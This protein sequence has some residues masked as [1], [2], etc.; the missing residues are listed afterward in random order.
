[1]VEG[2][3]FFLAGIGLLVY[4]AKETA[5]IMPQYWSISPYMLP[6]IIAVAMIL[7][8][9]I[10]FFQGL[11][12]QKRMGAEEKKAADPINWRG[13]L[14]ACGLVILYYILLP[15]IHFLPATVLFL[16]AFLYFLGERKPLRLVLIPLLTS[17]V[18]YLLFDVALSLMLP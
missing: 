9:V 13:V 12:E 7:M 3:V 2:I 1:M 5:K 17:G 18:L 4:S 14:G 15:L 16:A 11:A 10:L 6:S 8:S